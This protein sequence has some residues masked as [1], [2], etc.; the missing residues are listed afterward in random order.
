MKKTFKIL[1]AGGGTGGHL[2]SGVAVAD[3]I[4]RERPEDQVF[5]VGTERGLEKEIIPQA[6]YPLR[7]IQVSPLK[8]SGL[9][10]RLIALKDLPR[11]YRQSKALLQEIGP[12]IV[13]GIGGY[14]SGPMVLAAHRKKIF[15]A[16]IEQNSYPGLTNRILGRVARKIFIAFEKAREFFPREK[17]V[18]T[19]NPVRSFS[20]PP[21]PKPESPFTVFILGGSQGAHALNQ[22]M[23]EALPL[24]AGS[25]SRLH[26]LHQTGKHDFPW[27][28]DRYDATGFSSEVFAFSPDLAP[29]FHRAHLVLC[30]AGA[31]TI[32]ELKLLG[33]PSILVPYP[34]AADNHQYFNARE[35][36]EGGAARLCTNEKF[37]GP[38]VSEQIL[39]LMAH[40]ATL[41]AMG[42][43][44]LK[45]AKPEAARSILEACLSSL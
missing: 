33:L 37:K 1:F 40:P 22:G 27:V 30:R 34:Y 12:D 11:A 19:G 15:T 35:M 26:F 9:K 4:R 13:I 29:Y 16:I 32:A 43:K 21:S 3:L 28:R 25:K 23:M 6:G 38:Y 24:L 39:D 14:A 2:F 44:A 41:K 17:T 18:F 20:P 7:F 10:A 36:V 42:E 5:F 45:M 8:G 31:G